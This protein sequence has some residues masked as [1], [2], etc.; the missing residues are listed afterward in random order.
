L[1]WIALAGK[2]LELVLRIIDMNK[3]SPI[4]Q[5][6]LDLIIAALKEAPPPTPPPQAIKPE[7]AMVKEL[8]R[9]LVERRLGVA[10]RRVTSDDQT[11]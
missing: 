8:K 9:A 4:D 1:D 7:E 11:A 3:R 5:V 6:K 2:L 10:E